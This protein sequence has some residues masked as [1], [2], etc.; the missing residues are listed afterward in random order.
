MLLQRV[1]DFLVLTSPYFYIYTFEL[2]VGALNPRWWSES[3]QFEWCPLKRLAVHPISHPTVIVP[4]GS[5]KS[6]QGFV[7]RL[8]V[9][10]V[11]VE[12]YSCNE[13][14]ILFFDVLIHVRHS[15]LGKRETLAATRCI[16][17]AAPS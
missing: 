3:F 14:V 13:I 12:R 11:S 4:I 15:I 17:A 6:C 1:T 8:S 10:M 5:S 16:G 9:P 7:S 2:I